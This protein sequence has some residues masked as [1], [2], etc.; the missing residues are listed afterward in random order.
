MTPT[1]LWQRYLKTHPQA[2]DA[3]VSSYHFGD[4]KE[5]ANAA[6]TRI[7]LGEKTGCISFPQAFEAQ[8]APCPQPGDYAVITDFAGNGICIIQV[9]WVEELSIEQAFPVYRRMDTLEQDRS[10]WEEKQYAIQKKLCEETGQP[11]QE[12]LPVLLE[13]FRTVFKVKRVKVKQG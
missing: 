1:Q 2:A 8:G 13:S 11:W 6:V 4:A 10:A 7:C 5:E 3:L 9:L 12:D